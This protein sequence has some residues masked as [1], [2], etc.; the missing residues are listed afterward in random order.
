[1]WILLR[2]SLLLSKEYYTSLMFFKN[3]KAKENTI[4][5]T[6]E[7]PPRRRFERRQSDLCVI[8]INGSNYPVEDWSLGGL[9]IFCDPRDVK[10]GEMIDVTMKF[11]MRDSVLRIP[12]RG[13]IIRKMMDG[14]AMTFDMNDA[15]VQKQLQQVIDDANAAEFANSQA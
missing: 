13:T 15:N 5:T 6:Q 2:F 11:H 3:L 14:F 12:H 1:M 9:R 4:E 7:A 8:E 10:V